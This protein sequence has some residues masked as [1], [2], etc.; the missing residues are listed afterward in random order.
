MIVSRSKLT[1]SEH[2]ETKVV[3][4]SKMS[5]LKSS[6]KAFISFFNEYEAII[7]NTAD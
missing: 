7:K 5:D 2:D 4:Q 3:V 6:C 1:S